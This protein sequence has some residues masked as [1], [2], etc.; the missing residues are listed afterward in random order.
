MSRLIGEYEC[1]LDS[2]GRFILPSAL[3]KQVSD[4]ARDKF[5][6]NKGFEKCL[7]LYP[8]NEWDKITEDIDKLNT[9]SLENR[10]FIRH[11]YRGATEMTLDSAQR[12]LL[13]KSLQEYAGIDKDI[14]LFAH[15]NKIEIWAKDEY[16]KMLSSEPADF[17]GLAERVMGGKLS[18]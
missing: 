18:S 8:S 1:R 16:D 5:I 6:I 4:E 9:Y 11:F 10:T 7:T 15:T 13:A 12:L 2:K 14:V 3:K 17:A